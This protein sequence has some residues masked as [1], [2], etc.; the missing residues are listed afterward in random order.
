[1]G[2]ETWQRL[3]SQFLFCK[4]REPDQMISSHQ[5]VKLQRDAA[6]SGSLLGG[7]SL[8]LIDNCFRGR[9]GDGRTAHSGTESV[10]VGRCSQTTLGRGTQE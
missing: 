7:K 10:Q 5:G 9:G 4:M 2:R 6:S 8:W 3:G 1:M